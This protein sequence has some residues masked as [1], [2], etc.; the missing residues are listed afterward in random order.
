MLMLSLPVAREA[1]G[2]SLVERLTQ[3]TEKDDLEPPQ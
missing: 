2:R 1:N 3:S